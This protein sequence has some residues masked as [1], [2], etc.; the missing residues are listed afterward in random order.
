[1]RT[2]P[3]PVCRAP[4]CERAS[5]ARG[6][7]LMHYKRERAGKPL[8]A[9]TRPM[10]GSRSGYG[11]YGV[12]DDD[13]ET[14]LCHECG[15][16]F[17]SVGSHLRLA[18]GMTA[19]EYREV[20]GLP[21]GRSLVSA[22]AAGAMSRHARARV[23]STAWRRLEAARDPQAA[24]AAR[25]PGAFASTAAHRR[26]SLPVENGRRARRPRVVRCRQCAA[27]WCPLPGGY[28]RTHC[29]VDCLTAWLS[30]AHLGTRNPSRDARIV[31]QA[32]GRMR[33][34]A[35]VGRE[36][37][38]TKER[39]GQIARRHL[40]GAV[41]APLPYVVVRDEELR[42]VVIRARTGE[43]VRRLLPGE[44]MG[45]GNRVVRHMMGS[46]RGAPSVYCPLCIERAAGVPLSRRLP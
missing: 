4:G 41:G 19:R 27:S 13:G 24:A 7:C 29:S 20:H 14:V 25:D 10:V 42:P 11:R 32:L 31:A 9:P 38:V 46:H 15:R 43:V 3:R 37:G 44:P 16:R 36:F 6:L 22:A 12:L 23:G 30:T 26:Q 45:A 2:E 28:R 33:P 5:V 17:R 34:Y 1:M 40:E 18:H 39:V 35:D 21:R 8:A